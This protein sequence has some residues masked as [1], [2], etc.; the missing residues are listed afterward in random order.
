MT[1]FS[2]TAVGMVV[3]ASTAVFF[4][5][6]IMSPASAQN[7]NTDDANQ[8]GKID[9]SGNQTTAEVNSLSQPTRFSQRSS[10]PRSR[11]GNEVNFRPE[12]TRERG[13]LVPD[14]L[15]TYTNRS[16]PINR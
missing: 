14:R 11:T 9:W 16:E 13:G 10:I 2:T 1:K 5:T 4:A 8:V 7:R 3:T 12:P 15:N 6:A